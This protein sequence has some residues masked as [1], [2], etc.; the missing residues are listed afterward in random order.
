M[1]GEPVDVGFLKAWAANVAVTAMQLGAVAKSLGPTIALCKDWDESKHPRQAGR[2]AAAQGE[3]AGAKGMKAGQGGRGGS[4]ASTEASTNA[5]S[6]SR[7]A[8]DAS[9]AVR[10]APPGREEQAEAHDNA[11][12][13]HRKATEAH[14]DARSL[15][16]S[17]AQ[18]AAHATASEQHQAA[19]TAHQS[20]ANA[21]RQQPE[22][23][24]FGATDRESL[25]TR[26]ALA[27]SLRTY[28]TPARGQVTAPRP[29]GAPSALN[30][31]NFARH[32]ARGGGAPRRARAAA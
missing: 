23:D 22:G 15:A 13:V 29:G 11:A 14:E 24:A 9:A 2:F 18:A 26:R 19:A 4:A 27:E 25:D 28:L 3:D 12:E 5:R 10:S 8:R 21:L 17:P 31:G 20:A 30:P 32:T 6:A 1:H 16:S 7:E